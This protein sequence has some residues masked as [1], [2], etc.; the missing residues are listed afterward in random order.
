MTPLFIEE[1]KSHHKCP[2][3]S[4]DTGQKSL[5]RQHLEAAKL[6]WKIWRI[7][8]RKNGLCRHCHSPAVI[9]SPNCESHR[10]IQRKYMAGFYNRN[11]GYIKKAT[12]DRAIL[13]DK[14]TLK[15][16]CNCRM[17]NPIVEGKQYCKDCLKRQSLFFRL[18]YY[19]QTGHQDK[20]LYYTKQLDKHRQVIYNKN[21]K[22]LLSGLRETR[23]KLR[24][25]GYNYKARKASYPYFKKATKYY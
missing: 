11:P 10:K 8:R 25:L 23:Q 24:E 13:K 22:R 17:R 15:G 20:I 14:L 18:S 7:N 9:R 16:I 12:I 19:K 2:R 4:K 21:T 1:F 3:C 6:T 5:C